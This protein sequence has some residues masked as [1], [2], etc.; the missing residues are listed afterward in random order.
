MKYDLVYKWYIKFLWFLL[1]RVANLKILD[2]PY[3]PKYM[4]YMKYEIQLTPAL[5]AP[6]ETINLTNNI[7]KSPFENLCLFLYNGSNNISL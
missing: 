5:T 7:L 3:N 6:P 2:Y 4:K 1:V